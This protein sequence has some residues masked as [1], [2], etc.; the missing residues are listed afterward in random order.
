VDADGRDPIESAAPLVRGSIF[1][2]GFRE[3]VVQRLYFWRRKNDMRAWL[4]HRLRFSNKQKM[5]TLHCF[6]L[7]SAKNRVTP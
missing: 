2:H 5:L 6:S 7:S 3:Y 4:R 1:Q